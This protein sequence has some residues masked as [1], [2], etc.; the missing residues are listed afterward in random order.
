MSYKIAVGKTSADLEREVNNLIGKGYKPY[1]SP[2]C[3]QIEPMRETRQFQAMIFSP[4]K[5]MKREKAPRI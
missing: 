1:G 4:P 5:Q 3:L 2:Y